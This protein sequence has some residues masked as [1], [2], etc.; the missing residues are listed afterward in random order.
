MILRRK[1]LHFLL[2]MFFIILF[3]ISKTFALVTCLMALFTGLL[4]FA[5]FSDNK[6]IKWFLTYF[7]GQK[8]NGFSTF[9]YVLA[10]YLCFAF[11]EY[12]Y[13]TA[14]V[15]ILAIADAFSAVFGSKVDKKNKGFTLL[16]SA[17][18][19]VTSTTILGIFTNIVKA[20][21]IAAI[22]TPVEAIFSKLDNLIIPII[23]V[24]LLKF[25][26]I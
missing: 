15:L 14:S 21:I 7:G 22:I 19:F 12:N 24:S 2:G 17:I 3:G 25:L 16:G 20:V 4:I 1:T 18:F 6:S 11:F 5:F 10:I 9:Y 8:E 13:A 23:T 26:P